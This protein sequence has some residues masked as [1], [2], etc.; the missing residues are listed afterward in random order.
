MN[1]AE[2]ADSDRIWSDLLHDIGGSRP[3]DRWFAASLAPSALANV[4]GALG[5]ASERNVRAWRRRR[6]VPRAFRDVR[7]VDTRTELFGQSFSAPV[8][9]APWAAQLLIHPDGEEASARGI[10]RAGLGFGLSSSSSLPIDQVAQSSGPFLQQVYVPVNRE[11]LF[12]FLDKVVAAGAWGLALTVDAPA[13]AINT[14]FRPRAVV[15]SNDNWPQ[16]VPTGGAADLG[17]NDISLLRARSGLPVL[18]K[19]ILHPDDAIAAVDAGAD[20]VIVSNHGGRQLAS[21]LSTA[22][23]LPGIV[24]AVGARVPIVVDGG[25]RSAEDIVCALALGA[26]A[27]MLGRLFAWALAAGG[28]AGVAGV[29]IA[30]KDELRATM[31]RL[32]TPTRSDI[33]TASIWPLPAARC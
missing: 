9:A 22:E 33:T 3:L 1:P 23:A 18:C 30:L 29:A 2:P 19:G 21:G 28:E 25:I 4:N 14:P 11:E 6:L 13:V 5:D 7:E 15:A 16:G 10:R 32:G 24:Q 20:G 8:I 17:L 31:A 26:D 27:V 12:P